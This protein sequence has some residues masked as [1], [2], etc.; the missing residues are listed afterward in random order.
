LATLNDLAITTKAIPI[1]RQPNATAAI[2]KLAA[3]TA[4]TCA[5]TP[6]EVEGEVSHSMRLT[7]T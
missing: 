5:S 4:F 3:L 7:E 6:I 1:K 2:R